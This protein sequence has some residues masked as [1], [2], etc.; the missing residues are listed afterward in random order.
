MK[1][2]IVE[3]PAKARTIKGYLGQEFRVEASRGHIRELPE[4]ELGVD[5]ENGFAPTYVNQPD[6]RETIASIR[7]LAST[8]EVVFIATDP[9]REGEA[10]GQHIIDV[11]SPADRRK[12]RRVS[13][14]EITRK[15]ILAAIAKP[16]EID[17]RLVDAAKAR[18]VL[19]RLIGYKVSPVVWRSV[20]RGTSAGRVQSVALKLVCDRQR[21]IDAFKPVTYWYVDVLLG[22]EAGEFWARVVV[23]KDKRD[24]MRLVSQP[25][26]EVGSGTSQP[27]PSVRR[28]ESDNRFLDKKLATEA[29]ERLGKASFAMADVQ[30]ATKSVNP[31]PPFD[32]NG[33]QKAASSILKWDVTRTMRVAQSLYEA[34][35]VTYIRTD[36]YNVSDEAMAS[37]RALVQSAHGDRYLP[38]RPNAYSKKKAAAAQ[39]AHECIRPTHVEDDGAGLSGDDRKLYDLVRDAFVASQMSPMAV[40]TVKYLVDADCGEKLLASGQTISFDGFTRVWR[41]KSTKDE[42][43]PMASKGEKLA[44]KDSKQS[45]NRTKPP[46]RYTD[47]SLADKLEKDGVGRPATRAPII[48]ALEDKGYVTKDKSALVP[49]PMGLAIVDFL[50]PVFAQSFMDIKFTAGMEEEMI[51]IADGEAGFV[52]VVS[53]FYDALKA[54]IS[55]TK[56][57][58]K[59]GVKV[60]AKCSACG[61]GDV[62]EKDGKFG[63]FLACDRYPNCKTIFVRDGDKFVPQKK[64]EVVQTGKDCPKCGKPLVLRTSEY[65]KFVACS[66]FPACRHKENV[67]E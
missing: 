27:A 32:T 6:K 25:K 30:R 13:Y 10:I 28:D 58:R 24:G 21:E 59:P 44:Y 3:S 19:D 9:D 52:P 17:S 55:K 51:R 67:K 2:F 48:K 45:E 35:K 34:G 5:V 47:A 39:E 4:D 43:L 37:V 16:R 11:L 12:C 57:E 1:L 46:D 56:G 53:K 42:V 61:E 31:F 64:K 14:Q 60:G 29:L 62:V 23:P 66:G 41:H 38:A 40:D 49:T 7:S 54:D 15:A 50:A 63:K 22:C 20:G 36:S 8:A 26:G 65:W 33:M 18:Q